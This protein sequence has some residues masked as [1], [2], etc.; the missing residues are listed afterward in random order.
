MISNFNIKDITDDQ[1][2]NKRVLIR[3]DFNVDIDDDGKIIDDFRIVKSLPTI[4]ALLKN[5]NRLIL[6]SHLNKPKNRD[7]KYS[8]KP[9]ADYL[10][11]SL[12]DYQIILVDDFIDPKNQPVFQNQTNKQIILLEN[13]RFYPQEM[14]DNDQFAQQL[15]KLGDIFVNDAFGELHRKVT[16]IVSI[17]KYLSSYAGLLVKKEIETLNNILQ[18]PKRP[19]T[20]IV[21]GAKISTKI[22][23]ISKVIEIADNLLLAGEIANTLLSVNNENVTSDLSQSRSID[24]G[25]DP[26]TLQIAKNIIANNNQSKCKI[27]FPTDAIVANKTDFSN[28]STVN[29]N[30]VIKDQDIYDIGTKTIKKYQEIISQSSTVIWNGPLGLIEKSE[31]RSSTDAIFKTIIN[32]P[33]LTSIIGGGDT[34]TYLQS[35]PEI[36]KITHL[37]I[38][39]GAMLK[40]I[41]SGS[42][43]GLESLKEFKG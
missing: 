1:I 22:K 23:F 6:I 10:Q 11:Q 25:Y 39:G 27:Y 16:S 40:F 7:P 36:D 19:L 15:S 13:I 2:S 34:L 32:Q 38:G 31:F 41:E 24:I 30:Q 12:S 4:K 26:Q 28:V 5:D 35:K 8:L 9:V 17:P 21:G 33:N 20:F 3:N 37:S 43:I 18:A 42:L 14:A 29:I